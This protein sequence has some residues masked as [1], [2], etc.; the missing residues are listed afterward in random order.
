MYFTF[1]GLFGCY[2][3]NIVEGVAGASQHTVPN[4]ILYILTI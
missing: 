4:V 1:V 3:V 2:I